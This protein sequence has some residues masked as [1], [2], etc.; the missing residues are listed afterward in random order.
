L[1]PGV[2][3]RHHPSPAA[4]KLVNLF[5][6]RH[7][8]EE[9]G[10]AVGNGQLRVAVGRDAVLGAYVSEA[11]GSQH[12]DNE[13]Q[14]VSHGEQPKR[15]GALRSIG[16]RWIRGTGRTWREAFR[17]DGAGFTDRIN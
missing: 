6:Q 8:L 17:V 16:L 9:I 13:I 11:K 2:L 7:T 15:S 5:F 14:D 3:D 1:A 4:G 10:D 12:Q